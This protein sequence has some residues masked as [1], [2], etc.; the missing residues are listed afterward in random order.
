MLDFRGV[1]GSMNMVHWPRSK[2]K[3]N[4]PIL[5][6]V[7]ALG[8]HYG[9]LDVAN[10]HSQVWFGQI[11]GKGIRDL[12]KAAQFLEEL[13]REIWIPQTVAFV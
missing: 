2:D 12:R 13:F 8:Y 7:A 1:G 11:S 9:A 6:H 4:R 5:L 10:R 3:Q